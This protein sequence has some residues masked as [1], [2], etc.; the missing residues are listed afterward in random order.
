MLSGSQTALFDAQM[1]EVMAVQRTQPEQVRKDQLEYIDFYTY[2]NDANEKLLR[3]HADLR[4]ARLMKS[5]RSAL[6]YLGHQV[7]VPKGFGYQI[8]QLSGADQPIYVMNKLRPYSDDVTARWVQSNPQVEFAVLVEDERQRVKTLD[9]IRDLNDHFNILHFTERLLLSC[10]KFGQFDGNYCVE[11]YYDPD[12]RNGFQWFEEF[13]RQELP[14]ET[15][16]LCQDCGYTVNVTDPYNAVCEHCGSQNVEVQ[17]M[18]GAQIDVP[19]AAEWRN[20][21]EVVVKFSNPW[22]HHASYTTGFADSPWRYHEEDWAREYVEAKYGKLDQTATKTEWQHDELMHPDRVMR[23]ADRQ[24]GAAGSETPDEDDCILMQ[25][26]WREPE[27]LHYLACKAPVDLPNGQQVPAGVRLSEVFPRG[28][29]ILTAPGLPRFLDVVGDSHKERFVDG[30]YGL[31]PGQHI[32][33]GNE[34]SIEAQRQYNLL[35][36][37]E[38]KY[39]QRT[40]HPSII[41]KQKAFRGEPLRLFNRPD[42]VFQYKG[43]ED[44]R[45]IFST[46]Q[47]PELSPRIPLLM[48]RLDATMQQTTKSNNST[49]DYPGVMKETATASKIGENRNVMQSGLHLILFGGFMKEV[50][51]RTLTIAQNN[52]ESLRLIQSTEPLSA[53][54]RAKVLDVADLRYSVMAYVKEGSYQPELQ[55]IKRANFIAAT[56][57]RMKLQQA[58]MWT[59]ALARQVDDLFQTDFGQERTRERQ[60]QCEDEYEQMLASA[61]EALLQPT[62]E[63]GALFLYSLTPVEVEETGHEMKA[64][65]WRDLLSS[66]EG[67]ALPPVLREAIKLKIYAE[68]NAEVQNRAFI[69]QAAMSGAGLVA[70][71]VAQGLQPGE[72]QQPPPPAEAT[73]ETA[74]AGPERLAA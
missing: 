67:R 13:E 68:A 27:A 51:V 49:G 15:W 21:G 37:G 56:D 44:V 12:S 17:Q 50:R 40:F 52:Y 38:Y 30:I 70:P 61:N 22:S 26:F 62:L 59:P 11:I 74:Q 35:H 33:H 24:R 58:G 42:M 1:R 28:M 43:D 18:P 60:Y 69:A 3:R 23:R 72:V 9:A 2:F 65:W 29:M 14:E 45:S 39:V 46:I 34:D 36:S 19:K 8:K 10:A 20:S 5:L 7:L 66:P 63:A 31:S 47:A 41:A 6:Y 25:R 71:L 57:V 64:N 73:K 48:E 53:Q 4:K 32:G 55:E 54:R 16:G